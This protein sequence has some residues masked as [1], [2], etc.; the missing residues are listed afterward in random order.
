MRYTHLK[1]FARQSAL[2]LDTAREKIAPTRDER[3]VSLESPSSPFTPSSRPLL[4][5]YRGARPELAGKALLKTLGTTMLL[6]A[7][8]GS[9]AVGPRKPATTPS[10]PL[11]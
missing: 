8:A 9:S 7:L 11:P 2:S 3:N 1:G 10:M 6:C 4:A 5:A